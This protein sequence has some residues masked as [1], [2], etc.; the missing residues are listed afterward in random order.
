M[1]VHHSYLRLTREPRTPGIF[2]RLGVPSR[3]MHSNAAENSKDTRIHYIYTYTYRYIYIYIYIVWRLP[4]KIENNM[5]R[6]IVREIARVPSHIV[7]IGHDV[8][9][10]FYTGYRCPAPLSIDSLASLYVLQFPLLSSSF[11]CTFFFTRHTG[12][13]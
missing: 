9:P 2:H 11:F 6:H 1:V 12:K 13:S 3:E 7:H 8:Q 5:P 10:R 4:E